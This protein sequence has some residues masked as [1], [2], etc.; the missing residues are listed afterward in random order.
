MKKIKVILL[1]TVLETSFNL[2]SSHVNVNQ[3]PEETV[4]LNVLL[5]FT[6]F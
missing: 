4:F 1:S 2:E 6:M 3:R 5:L